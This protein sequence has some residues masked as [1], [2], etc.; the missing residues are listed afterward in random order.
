MRGQWTLVALVGALTLFASGVARAAQ[1]E[2]PRELEG[3]YELGAEAEA[4]TEH[5]GAMRCSCGGTVIVDVIVVDGVTIRPQ[6]PTSSDVRPNCYLTKT[7]TPA[8][9]GVETPGRFRVAAVDVPVRVDHFYCRT[10]GCYLFGFI[11]S[12]SCRYDRTT[13]NG[14]VTTHRIVGTCSG[15]GVQG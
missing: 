9:R 10:S 1:E 11:G 5:S 13:Q 15:G 6:L 4:R 14:H 3:C 12:A 7:L 2:E 8:H